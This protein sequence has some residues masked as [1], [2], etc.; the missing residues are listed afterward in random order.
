ME[1]YLNSF[2]SDPLF[3]IG[4]AFSIAAVFAFL[5]FLRGFLTGIPELFTNNS[6]YEHLRVAY[7]R[8]LWGTAL[9]VIIFSAWEVI[10]LVASWFGVGTTSPGLAGTIIVIVLVGFVWSKARKSL[11]GENGGGH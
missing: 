6:N 1:S 2:L 5:I 10:R 11:K 8:V 7:T 4:A 9:L 3:Y